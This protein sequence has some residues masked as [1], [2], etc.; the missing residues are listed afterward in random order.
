ML[1]ALL[2]G[3]LPDDSPSG[4]PLDADVRWTKLIKEIRQRFKGTLILALYYPDELTALPKF[5]S[6]VDQ[7][8][9]L[10]SAPLNKS[11][12]TQAGHDGRIPE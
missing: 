7:V 1:P 2:N 12:A 4:V 10:V 8:Y 11:K 9:V 5:I 6:S 3:K